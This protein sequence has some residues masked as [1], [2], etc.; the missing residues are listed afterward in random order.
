ME[1]KSQCVTG[2]DA[3]SCC[4]SSYKC[5]PL[6]GMLPLA[7]ELTQR[8]TEVILAANSRPSINDITAPELVDVL[9]RA[10]ALDCHLG[11]AVQ[12]ECLKVV[13]SGSDLP[14]IDLRKVRLAINVCHVNSNTH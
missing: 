5:N 1:S 13:P 14:V 2:R 6:A 12:E 9:N 11:R 3:W 10:A 7:R 4:E 8:G